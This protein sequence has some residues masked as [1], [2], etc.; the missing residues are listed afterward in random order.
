MQAANELSSV[1]SDEAGEDV[2]EGQESVEVTVKVGQ[3]EVEVDE[4]RA[5]RNVAVAD[6]KE[7]SEAQASVQLELDASAAANNSTTT[8]TD[9]KKVSYYLK[10]CAIEF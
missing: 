9:E 10:R 2:K 8:T 4:A 5:K 1:A 7:A 6:P 3:S